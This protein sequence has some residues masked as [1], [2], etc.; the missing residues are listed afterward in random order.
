MATEKLISLEVVSPDIGLT[1][2]ADRDKITQVLLNLIGN[3]VK[4]TP[5]YGKV[6]V[7][8]QKNGDEWVQI[9]ITDTGPGIQTDQVDKI[10]DKF[11]QIAQ[12][13][14]Q[15]TKGTG[16]GLAISKALVEMHG[17]R[18]WMES[19]VGKGS[20]FSFTLPARQPFKFELPT[21]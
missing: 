11:Y 20:T 4:F 7:A 2:W 12:V 13:T 10:F 5:P 15:K 3:A 14:K 17:G 21:K 16:L 1:A 6:G 9:S 8:I 19:E 18:I